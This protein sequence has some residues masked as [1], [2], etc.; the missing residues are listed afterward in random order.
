MRYY[1]PSSTFLEKSM[2]TI[3]K[4]T[5][6]AGMVFYGDFK[7]KAYYDV[8]FHLE[9]ITCFLCHLIRATLNLLAAI[10]R[11]GTL[12]LSVLIPFTW[13]LLPLKAYKILDNLGASL[14]SLF[15]IGIYPLIVL[16]RSLSS[17]I[18]GYEKGTKYDCGVQ[19]EEEDLAL[20]L[21][22]FDN[23]EGGREASPMQAKP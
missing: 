16:A 6:V 14:I 15:T 19:A 20:A 23:D 12:M 5:R 21:A 8:G 7:F 4:S 1:L 17:V 11:T 2:P 3:F 9:A 10:L 13:P 22:I 18:Y